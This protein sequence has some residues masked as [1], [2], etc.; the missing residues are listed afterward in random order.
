MPAEWKPAKTPEL[1]PSSLDGDSSSLPSDA[2]RAHPRPLESTLRPDT[3]DVSVSGLAGI[4]HVRCG[5]DCLETL[6]LSGLPGT[7][8]RWMD[9][10]CEGPTPT[11]LDDDGFRRIR[12][13]WLA[14]RYHLN[15]DALLATFREQD[16]A[17]E[18][19]AIDSHE[20]LLWIEPNLFD[21]LIL[22]RLLD[23]LWPLAGG[24]LSLISVDRRPGGGRLVGFGQLGPAALAALFP[25]RRRVTATQAAVA[26][27][28]WRAFTATTP[29]PLE[30]L[31]M[32]KKLEAL[33]FLKAALDR[34][35]R[36]YP[37]RRH[38]LSLTEWR[39]LEAV[40]GGAT[41]S[42]AVFAF[43]QA[44]E[45]APWQGLAMIEAG[46]RDLASGFAPALTL[47]ADTPNERPLALTETGQAILEGRET[48]PPRE[49]WL[50]G[51]HLD[52]LNSEPDR[53]VWYWDEGSRS[54]GVR[55][56]IGISR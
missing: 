37:W 47:N 31:V 7:I 24:R 54:L 9:P 11:D 26:S 15:S 12:A 36:Q 44:R 49:R 41:T 39:T 28:A 55:A 19:A 10:L 3:G 35:R 48:A 29:E 20:V 43:L 52:A 4:I 51:V 13:D 1:I 6:R 23:R 18:R 33:P 30:R 34:H 38:G 17:L 40:A 8:L 22:I 2:G 50:G 21:Q 42:R 46:L 56:G 45:R 27:Q 16:Q 14:E 32:T 53:T 5:D 25:S